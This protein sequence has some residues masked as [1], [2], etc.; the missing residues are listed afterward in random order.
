MNTERQKVI[1]LLFSCD[2]KKSNNSIWLA[3][4]ST[5]L[6]KIKQALEWE[7]RRKNMIYGKNN[8]TNPVAMVRALRDDWKEAKKENDFSLLL[9]KINDN[10]QWGFLDVIEDGDSY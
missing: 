6:T 4:A 1:Y 5:T 3:S 10:L 7:I 2:E 9:S 8:E